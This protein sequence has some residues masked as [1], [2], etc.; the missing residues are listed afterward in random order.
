MHE[1]AEAILNFWL[2]EIGPAGW[3]EPPKGLDET[4]RARFA[5]D[6]D[7]ARRG[8]YDTWVCNP[9]SCLALII[10]LDQF[11]RNMFRGEARA[12][13]TDSLERRHAVLKARMAD[14]I[15]A[16]DALIARE[17]GAE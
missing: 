4:I 3:Y 6:W 15:V 17:E 9:R 16:I 8:T 12:F 2:D 14:A 7:E 1:R 11:P 5:A 13:A 10:L